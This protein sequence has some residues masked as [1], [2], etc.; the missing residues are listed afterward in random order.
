MEGGGRSK[1]EEGKGARKNGEEQASQNFYSSAM[2][3]TS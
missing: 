2:A 3:I 1:R